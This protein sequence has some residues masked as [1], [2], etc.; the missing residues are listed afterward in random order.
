MKLIKL[1]VLIFLLGTFPGYAQ[2]GF[3]S[4]TSGEPI[5]V[6][7]FGTGT[8]NGP[9]LPSTVTTYNYVTGYGSFAAG[10]YTISNTTDYHA[11][12][13]TGDHTPGD[14]N[15]KC[16]VV[17]GSFSTG[18]FYQIQVEELCEFTTYEFSAFVLNLINPATTSCNPAIPINVTFEIW[19]ETN[20]VLIASGDTGNVYESSEITWNQY[21]LVFQT[22]AGQTS[23]ILKMINNAPGGCGND[24]AIDDIVFKACGDTTVVTDELGN[25]ETSICNSAIPYDLDLIATPDYAVYTTHAFQ[26]QESVDGVNW[27]DIPGVTTQNVTVTVN[28]PTYFRTKVA[29]AAINLSNDQC[30]TYSEVFFIDINPDPALAISAGDVDFNCDTGQAV[31]SVTAENGLLVNWYDEPADGNLLAEN[32]L[33]YEATM[34]GSFYVETVDPVT[35]CVSVSRTEVSAIGVIP[36]APL[37]NGDVDFNCYDGS[38]LLS[39]SVPDGVQVNWYDAETDGTLLLAN[40]PTYE[41]LQEGTYYVEAVILGTGCTSETRTPVSTTITYPELPL[42]A[43]DVFVCEEGTAELSVTVPDGVTVNW[44]DAE[45]GGNLLVEDSTSIEVSELGTY[46]AVAVFEDTGCASQGSTP[47]SLN[48]FETPEVWDETLYF[49]EGE[50]IMLH[51]DIMDVS[52]LWNTGQ[53]TEGINVNEPGVYTV[54]VTSPE[55]CKATKSITLIEIGPPVI[56]SVVSDGATIIITMQNE[57]DYM[58]SLDG[59][60]Y[61]SSN[62]FNN[63]PG[64]Y[65]TIHVQEINGCEEAVMEYLHFMIPKLMTPNFDGHNDRFDL[66]GIESFSS[67]EVY[68]FDRF[69]KLLVS[70]RNTS[71]AWDGTYN[72][73]LMPTSDYWYLIKIEGQVFQGHFTLKR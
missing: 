16:M 54:E 60:D 46:Y 71:F 21:G 42:S 45:T 23:V 10:E 73:A 64:G 51:A 27:T 32:G 50:Y 33:S 25:T 56:Q 28:G 11:W 34:V 59:I 20:S 29:E 41:V 35:G 26:W 22:E 44:Y 58:Y 37:S 62:A 31:L 67:S 57:G 15:G 9:P 1:I 48:L 69:G 4:G 70:S 6:E 72:D 5:F 40:S 8:S 38:A 43:G 63:V 13:E 18:V 24:L 55:G 53:T 12:Y 66:V 3:C 30:I 52:Y 65:Y 39:V 7:D 14:V 49:C 17:N 36:E 2:L 68:V 19:D 61:Q 47:V